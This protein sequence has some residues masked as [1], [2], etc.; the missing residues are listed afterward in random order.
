MM[1]EDPINLQM[2]DHHEE[3][4][5]DTFYKPALTI[6]ID[7]EVPTPTLGPITHGAS[8]LPIQTPRVT[9]EEMLNMDG[10]QN[11]F[12]QRNFSDV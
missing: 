6:D 4:K 12:M 7:D 2:D 10:D 9:C 11:D 5:N 3:E 1:S 8:K